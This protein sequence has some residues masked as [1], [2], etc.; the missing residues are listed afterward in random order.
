MDLTM[1]WKII[2]DARA[3]ARDDEA[4][5]ETIR[6]RLC[7]LSPE[8]LIGFQNHF[9]EALKQSYSWRLWGAAYL[10]CGGCGDDCFDYLRAWLITQGRETFE[11][12]LRDPDALVTLTVPDDKL[13]A[14]MY[15]AHDAY[16]E[17]T[18]EE[19]PTSVVVQGSPP[20]IDQDWN[21]SNDAEMKRRYPKL[22]AKYRNT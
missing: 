21:F 14:F 16:E 15:Y 19:M 12:V 20:R 18:G 7:L 10:M 4:F 1:F 13:E 22:F 11:M 6:S 17:M 8:E 3:A 2:W 5:L 9:D